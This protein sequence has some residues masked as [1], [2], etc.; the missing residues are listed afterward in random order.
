MAYEYRSGY[1]IEPMQV[2]HPTSVVVCG[3]GTG[4]IGIFLVDKDPVPYLF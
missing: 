2:Y 4:R 1:V 3:S